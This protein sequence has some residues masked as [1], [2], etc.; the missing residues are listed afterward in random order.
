MTQ[1]TNYIH[2]KKTF[3]SLWVILSIVISNSPIFAQSIRREVNQFNS[4][5]V[6][7][8]THQV[9]RNFSLFTDAQ[10]RRSGLI[11]NGQQLL[12]RT[13][14][15]YKLSDQISVAGG[16]AYV[17]TYPYGEQPTLHQFNEHRLFEQLILKSKSGRLNFNHRYRLEQRFLERYVLGMDDKIIK[18]DNFYLNRFRYRLLCNIPLNKSS[19]ENNTVFLS[20]TNEMFVNFGKEARFNLFDQ[21]RAFIG[22]GYQINTN[23]NITLGYLNHRLIKS[24]GIDVEQNHTLQLGVVYNLK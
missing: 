8:G 6:F 14:I 16:Y 21:N 10:I 5:Y 3:F 22:M 17:E 15:D 12:L 2:M 7:S 11:R 24:N 20:C 1:K 23:S 9:Y 18:G 4:W 19:M 13:A